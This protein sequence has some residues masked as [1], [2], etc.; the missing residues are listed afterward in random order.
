MIIVYKKS[1]DRDRYIEDDIYTEDIIKKIN[2]WDA[3]FKRNNDYHIIAEIASHY[4]S[5]S[6]SYEEF[7]HLYM[8]VTPYSMIAKFDLDN[9]YLVHKTYDILKTALELHKL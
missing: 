6:H 9:S 7:H 2:E 3:H 5:E 1:K 4:G 8:L